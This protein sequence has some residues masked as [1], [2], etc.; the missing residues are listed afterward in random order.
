MRDL[1]ASKWKQK[2]LD[3]WKRDRQID[4]YIDRQIDRRRGREERGTQYK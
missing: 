1:K 3:E 2:K 4:R